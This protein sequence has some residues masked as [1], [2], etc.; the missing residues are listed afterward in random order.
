MGLAG[1]SNFTS[2]PG[3]GNLLVPGAVVILLFFGT[4][5]FM[6]GKIRKTDVNL[7]TVE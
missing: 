5:W 3:I 1:I 2:H 6:A 4:A 7:L